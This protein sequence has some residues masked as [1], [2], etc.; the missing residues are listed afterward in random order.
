VRI[1]SLRVDH[2]AGKP[3]RLTLKPKQKRT[4]ARGGIPRRTC[5]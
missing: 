1:F 4:G 2:E 5:H 3:A